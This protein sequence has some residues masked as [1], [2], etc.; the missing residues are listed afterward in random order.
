MPIKL[1]CSFNLIGFDFLNL[2]ELELLK[3]LSVVLTGFVYALAVLDLYEQ[4]H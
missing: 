3:E 1:T 4:A 2:A